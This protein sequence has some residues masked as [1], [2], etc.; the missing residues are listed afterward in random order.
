[1]LTVMRTWPSEQSSKSHIVQEPRTN[2]VETD[3]VMSTLSG[4]PRSTMVF[5]VDDSGG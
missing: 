1:M 2:P 5:D 3:G 4:I